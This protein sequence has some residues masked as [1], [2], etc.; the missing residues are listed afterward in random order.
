MHL[1]FES[2]LNAFLV[3]FLWFHCTPHGRVILQFF[4]NMLF[5]SNLRTMYVTLNRKYQVSVNICTGVILRMKV[6]Q[7]EIKLAYRIP[8]GNLQIVHFYQVSMCLQIYF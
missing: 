5:I 3:A 4:I 8:L 1:R 7:S 2:L 6:F